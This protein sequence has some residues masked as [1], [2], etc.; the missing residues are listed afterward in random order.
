LLA[1]EAQQVKQFRPTKKNK[2][3]PREYEK[4]VNA[5]GKVRNIW[6]LYRID[7]KHIVE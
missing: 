4:D 7:L 3:E 5:E 6:W 1:F 2:K